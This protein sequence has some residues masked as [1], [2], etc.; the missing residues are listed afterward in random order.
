[1]VNNPPLDPSSTE[2]KI[3]EAAKKV[4]I[5]NGFDG[6]SMQLI[7]NEACI[8]K[9][10]LHY[11]FRSKEK[12]F[13]AVFLYAFQHFV[14]QIQG[15]LSSE[16]SLPA[17]IESIVAEYMTMLLNNEIIPAFILHEINRNP[18]RIYQIMQESGLNQRIFIDQFTRE[19]GKGL[20]RSVD[21]RH[22]IVNIIS[23]CVFP[24]AA[25]PLMQRILFANDSEAYHRFLMERKN[26]VTR[27]IIQSIQT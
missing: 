9:S 16:Q 20:V 4:F 27:F 22:F 26:V 11:Y 23:L 19:I 12:L 15:I 17:K 18:D 14:P 3:L 13:S 7:A 6:T 5:R 25:K 1:M 24:I 10:L 8:N 2:S 21:P